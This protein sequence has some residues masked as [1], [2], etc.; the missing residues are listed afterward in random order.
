MHPAVFE[1][2]LEERREY[3]ANLT[4]QEL[5]LLSIKE[6]L[7][8]S[9]KSNSVIESSKDFNLIDLKNFIE[10]ECSDPDDRER[11]K[12]AL[13]KLICY[14]VGNVP[15]Y[16]MPENDPDYGRSRCTGLSVYYPFKFDKDKLT[17][18]LG[19]CPIKKYAGMLENIYLKQE[20]M[21]LSFADSGSINENGRFEIT[22]TDESKPY[23][24]YLIGKL[25]KEDTDGSTYD[26]DSYGLALTFTTSTGNGMKG[27]AGADINLSN[28]ADFF[29]FSS[30]QKYKKWFRMVKMAAPEF[31]NN[32]ISQD[33]KL[34]TLLNSGSYIHT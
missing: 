14:Q 19:I 22:L 30:A 18:Y 23:F 20:D 11:A 26:Y 21:S 34:R 16:T 15:D 27:G 24:D 7:T 33:R 4:P 8:F 3:F 28:G 1:N 17:K 12:A 32:L 25:W 9:A 2:E 10:D 6:L 13:D 5:S 31:G 29:K